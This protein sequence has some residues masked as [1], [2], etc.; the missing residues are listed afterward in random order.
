MFKVTKKQYLS[1]WFTLDKFEKKNDSFI[2]H[3]LLEPKVLTSYQCLAYITNIW[4]SACLIQ[5]KFQIFL[6]KTYNESWSA[7][8]LVPFDVHQLL[9]SRSGTDCP[10]WRHN[11][12]VGPV[13]A[14]GWLHVT[15]YHTILFVYKKIPFLHY[16]YCLLQTDTSSIGKRP[17]QQEM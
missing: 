9:S 11:V 2:F 13:V 7:R 4:T 1:I 14:A 17:S 16:C 5:T 12:V 10:V 8:K 6:C 15:T 3:T